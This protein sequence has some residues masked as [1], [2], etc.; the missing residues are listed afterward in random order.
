MHGVIFA[1]LNDYVEA[2]H[3]ADGWEAV[4]DEAGLESKSYMPIKTY[5]DE[6]LLALVEAAVTVTG[7]S[8][9]EVLRDFG[10]FA[11][12]DLLDSYDAFLD[13]E[14]GPLDVLEHTEDAMH[15]AV[16]LK[17]DDAT[18]PEL[19]CRRAG[20]DEVVIEYGSDHQLCSLGEG[21][22]EGIGR[23]YEADLEIRQEQCMNEF[24]PVCE[25]HVERA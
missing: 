21:L 9:D 17:E 16:R 19:E 13:D 2:K 7:A 12:P 25:I 18:P 22:I 1:E 4:L 5:P 24:D 10:R 11:V 6:E 20:D 3:G 15:K 8:Q 14:W 23:E